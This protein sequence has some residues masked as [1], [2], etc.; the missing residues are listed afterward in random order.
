MMLAGAA[1]RVA[2]AAPLSRPKFYWGV[3]IENCW[4]AQVD[5]AKDGNRRLLDVFLQ[6]QHYD[7]VEAGPGPGRRVGCNCIRYSVPWYKAEPKP[8]VYDWSW[9]D[10]PVDYL[11]HKLKI[12]PIMD[13]IHYGTPAWMADGV[14]DPR[15]RRGHRPLCRRHG[16]PFQGPGQPLLAAQRA[17]ADVPVLRTGGALAAL[18]EERSKL[19]EDRRAG[20]QGDGAGDGGHPAGDC[21]MR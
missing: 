16:K 5:P 6:M 15:F 7:K 12:I 13:L 4:M 11:V 20:G 8:G 19:G 10:K 1:G 14:I 3:G 21:R 18:P 17:G 9:I 2:Q